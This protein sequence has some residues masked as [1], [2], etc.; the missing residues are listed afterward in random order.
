[1]YSVC[2]GFP[3]WLGGKESACNAGDTGQIPRSRRSPG[4][5]MGNPLQ[6]SWLE[7]SMDRGA[8]WA[9][10]H[11]VTKSQTWLSSSATTITIQ[12]VVTW[13]WFFFSL[14]E[15]FLRFGHFFPKF[16]WVG[17]DV[18]PFQ[19]PAQYQIQSD[20]MSV[21]VHPLV[22][23]TSVPEWETPGLGWMLGPL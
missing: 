14:S 4:K 7:N 13:K 21:L 10:V 15:G 23:K 3:W 11:G 2:K 5:E 22:G 1:M 17:G 19:H 9:T 8:W 12:F 18:T 20:R 16:W 6:Y